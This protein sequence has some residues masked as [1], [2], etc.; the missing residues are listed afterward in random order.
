MNDAGQIVGVGL[1]TNSNNGFLQGRGFLYSGGVYTPIS[2]SGSY[3]TD[4]IS[5]NDSGEIVGN[6]E[7]GTGASV[8]FLYVDGVY[9]AIDFPGSISTQLTG[10]NNLGQI[11]GFYKDADNNVNGL[12]YSD[13]TY[14]TIDFPGASSTVPTAINDLS[15]IVGY[16][17]GNEGFLA[18]LGPASVPESSTWTMILLGFAGLGYVGRPWSRT[19]QQGAHPAFRKALTEQRISIGVP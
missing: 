1:Y 10:I 13:G 5:I 9:T 4:P 16:Y 19:V 3:E 14:T 7:T 11:V 15:N 6:Y 8:G 12:L 18:M 17:D 2:V